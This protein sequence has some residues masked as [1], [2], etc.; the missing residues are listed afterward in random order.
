MS[1][2]FST[3]LPEDTRTK[4]RPVAMFLVRFMFR[5]FGM[6]DT[7]YS[8]FLVTELHVWMLGVRT[9]LNNNILFL[10]APFQP[11][12]ERRGGTLCLWEIFLTGTV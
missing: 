4:N 9:Q 10:N 11:F 6:A 5:T 8:W 7:Y 2:I 12:I 3:C 1:L